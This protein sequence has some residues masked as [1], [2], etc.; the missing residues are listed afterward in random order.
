MAPTGINRPGYSSSPTGINRPGYSSP[1]PPTGV[2]RPGYSSSPSPKPS[3]SAPTGINRPGRS[4]SQGGGG[5]DPLQETRQKFFD[6]RYDVSTDRLQRRRQQDLQDELFRE[7]F[8]K[9]VQGSSNLLQMTAD[10]PMSLS[11]FRM[12]LANKLGPTP[13]ELMGDARYAF[14]SMAQ[15]L[16]EKG[17]PMMNLAKDLIGGV[18]NLF[19]GASQA[20]TT[21]P[22]PSANMMQTSIPMGNLTE[23]GQM[24]ANRIRADRPGIS[25][26]ELMQVLQ[27]SNDAGFATQGRPVFTTGMYAKGGI[28]TLS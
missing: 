10:A 23:F 21:V 22:M 16:A 18:Q 14:G 5:I 1:K 3:F 17:T 15:G 7:M 28:A 8:T 26:A 9:P 11:D 24:L 6:N 4:P 12:Q 19:T 2:N 13:S 20:P 25:N 27:R